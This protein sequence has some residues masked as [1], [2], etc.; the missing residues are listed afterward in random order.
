M[1]PSVTQQ[2]WRWRG[3]MTDFCAAYPPPGAPKLPA[4]TPAILL[5]HGFGAFGDQWRGNLEALAA[6]GYTVYAPTF[7]GFGRS[8]KVAVPYSQLLWAD[9]LRDF[10]VQVVGR[11]VVMAGNSIGGFISTS[12]AADYPDLVRGLVLLNSAGPID[13]AYSDADWERQRAAKKAPPTWVVQ[14]V[15]SGLFWYL[16]RTVPGT[17]KWLYPTAPQ[18]TEGWLATEI[19]RAA[20]DIGSVAV[21]ASVF[22]LPPPKALNWLIN[23]RI[24]A[25]VMVLQG[26]LDPLNDAKGRAAELEQLCPDYVTKVLLQAGHCPHDEVPEQVNRHLMDFIQQRVM[27]A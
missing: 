6:A 18:R 24:R 23:E 12:M 16:E 9:F 27:K 13:K 5:V 10:V 21:F 7:P 20:A 15:S 11:P 2:H 26:A 25:P 14:A 4:D 22:Y 19:S 17:L 3:F 8:E 1:P